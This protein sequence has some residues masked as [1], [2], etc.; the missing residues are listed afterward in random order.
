MRFPGPSV[1][2]SCQVDALWNAAGFLQ[3]I[4]SSSRRDFEYVS[5]VTPLSIEI[6]GLTRRVRRHD[7]NSDLTNSTRT[8]RLRLIRLELLRSP[9]DACRHRH[10]SSAGRCRVCMRHIDTYRLF[11]AEL[12]FDCVF[13]ISNRRQSSFTFLSLIKGVPSRFHSFSSAAVCVP[14]E[15]SIILRCWL[16]SFLAGYS[17]CL[18]SESLRVR[19]DSPPM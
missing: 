13:R 4:C 11:S 18:S 19:L 14:L 6:P 15:K 7:C 3:T 10:G 16:R 2:R 9:L 8:L 5:I 17:D 1:R 12:G